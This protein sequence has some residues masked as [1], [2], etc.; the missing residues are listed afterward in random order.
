[1]CVGGERDEKKRKK[2]QEKESDN[3]NNEPS[4]MNKTAGKRTSQ[5]QH[6]HPILFLKAA[7][8]RITIIKQ[9]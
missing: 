2:E 1:M 4:R 9:N 7:G 8:E 3:E 6:C 5:L